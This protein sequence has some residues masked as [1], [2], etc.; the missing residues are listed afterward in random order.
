[1]RAAIAKW[2]NSLAL[3]LPQALAADARLYEGTR[4]DL[5][6]EG[7]KLVITLARPRYKLSELLAQ[8]KPEH[9]HEETDWGES[10]GDESW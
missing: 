1:M 10:K 8:M 6:I 3:R 5:K 9:T 4:V 2:G 7:E